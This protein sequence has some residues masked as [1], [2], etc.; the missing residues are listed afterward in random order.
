LSFPFRIPCRIPCMVCPTIRT[1]ERMPNKSA[2]HYGSPG[3]DAGRTEG[4]ARRWPK[5]EDETPWI[6]FA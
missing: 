1:S 2:D 3:A 6:R 4:H 5:K